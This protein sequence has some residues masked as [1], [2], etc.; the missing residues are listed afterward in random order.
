MNGV[1][2]CGKSVENPNCFFHSSILFLCDFLSISFAAQAQLVNVRV[3]VILATRQPYSNC[4]GCNGNPEAVWRMKGATNGTGSLPIVSTLLHAPPNIAT[5]FWSFSSSNQMIQHTNTDAIQVQ[6]S[7]EGWEDNCPYG[8]PT[9]YEDNLVCRC[10]NPFKDCSDNR[11]ANCANIRI[12][13][14]RNEPPC[15]RNE[16][17]TDWSGDFKYKVNIELTLLVPPAITVQPTPNQ[18]LCAGV[19]TSHTSATSATGSG[20]SFQWQVSSNTS[21]SS[22][23][24]WIDVPGATSLTFIP[25]QP[26]AHSFTD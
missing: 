14:F 6:L 8:Q 24:T 7:L 15:Q 12:I 26:P 9:V 5:T 11:H 22:P 18:V 23:G 2:F 20:V 4:T 17:E 25:P 10:E 3:E 21:C 19:S 16:Y 13:N 1:V